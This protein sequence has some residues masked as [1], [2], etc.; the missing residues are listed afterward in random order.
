MDGCMDGCMDGWMCGR[1]D[2]LMRVKP[3]LRDRLAQ[4]ENSTLIPATVLQKSY[5][6]FNG[7]LFFIK[8]TRDRIKLIVNSVNFEYLP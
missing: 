1:I 2:R 3:D 4:S 6:L 8:F 5:L 7:C